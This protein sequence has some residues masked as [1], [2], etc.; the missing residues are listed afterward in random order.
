MRGSPRFALC[1]VL[2]IALAACAGDT[3]EPKVEYRT[4]YVPVSA[5]CVV[6]RPEPVRP[7]NEQMTPEQWA[8]LPPGAKAEAIKA[9]AGDRMNYSDSLEASTSGCKSAEPGR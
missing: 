8:T 2:L 1:A 6:D 5:G 7:L 9:Q 4:V 3:P